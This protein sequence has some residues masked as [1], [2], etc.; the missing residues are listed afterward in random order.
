[1]D[2]NRFCSSKPEFNV[3]SLLFFE[4]KTKAKKKRKKKLNS[5]ISDVTLC[6][7]TLGPCDCV[8]TTQKK[9]SATMRSTTYSH[10][11]EKKEHGDLFNKSQQ[12]PAFIVIVISG[13]STNNNNQRSGNLFSLFSPL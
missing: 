2:D 13:S 6:T 12:H 4:R 3:R 7:E 9:G 1:M 10:H 8:I 5:M 11:L